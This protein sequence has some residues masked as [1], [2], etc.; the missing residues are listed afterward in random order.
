MYSNLRESTSGSPPP[1]LSHL[2]ATDGDEDRARI[3]VAR[4]KAPSHA[5]SQEKYRRWSKNQRKCLQCQLLFW[6]GTNG[7]ESILLQLSIDWLIGNPTP[8]I[9]LAADVLHAFMASASLKSLHNPKRKHDE[10]T[11]RG[12]RV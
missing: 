11:R 12:C 1:S 8:V 5:D 4:P 7:L 3:C 2:S 10:D 6:V 9:G